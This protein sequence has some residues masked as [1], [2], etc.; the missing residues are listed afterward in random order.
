LLYNGANEV[1]KGLV[2]NMSKIAVVTG[3][4]RGVGFELAKQLLEK[5]FKVFAG[6]YAADWNLLDEL[7]QKYGEKLETITLDV[8]SDE[9][10]KGAAN[11]IKSKTDYIDI[12]INNAAILGD[13]KAT[14]LDELNFDEMMKVYNVNALGAL[15]VSNSLASTVLKSSTKLIVNISSEAGSITDSYRKGWFA[16]CMSKAAL[17]MHATIV[18]NE[19]KNHGGMVL[20]MHPGWVQ[21]Y[22]SGK[23]NTQA[24]LLPAESAE[25]IL[26]VVFDYKNY[27]S[28]KA[29][30]VDYLGKKIDW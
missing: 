8:S 30:Y 5:G 10:V 6:R 19:L 17:N 4:D 28:E 9:S 14:I 11:Y 21:G 13:T 15:R 12:L 23:L 26:K 22:L 16:Y 25:H 29:V 3:A 7:A 18:H 1:M 20:N 2:I 24:T 27:D